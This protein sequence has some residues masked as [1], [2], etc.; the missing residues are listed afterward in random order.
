MCLFIAKI[1]QRTCHFP[2]FC[3]K[4]ALFSAFSKQHLNYAKVSIKFKL[5]HKKYPFN[6]DDKDFIKINNLRKKFYNLRLIGCDKNLYNGLGYG[7][8]SKRYKNTQQFIISGSQTGH[9]KNTLKEHYSQVQC[10]NIEL[11]HIKSL[12]M[13]KPSSESLTHAVFYQLDKSIKW[14]V[15]I[16]NNKLWSLCKKLNFPVVNHKISYG[17]IKMAEIVGELYKNTTSKE[18]GIFVM[19]GHQDGLIL[20][21][22]T[23][24]KIFKILDNFYEIQK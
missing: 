2:H 6:F 16:H 4:N 11:N 5:E 22:T 18:S 23:K 21:S 24:N 14:V 7:N 15:H 12:G 19:L 3:Y 10:C 13:V 20:Y 1:R 9:I 17:T 8:I